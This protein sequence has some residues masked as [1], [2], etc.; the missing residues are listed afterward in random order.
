MVHLAGSVR[1][2]SSSPSRQTANRRRPDW[3]LPFRIWPVYG[4][5]TS[6]GRATFGPPG[7][8]KLEGLAVSRE[9]WVQIPTKAEH[10]VRDSSSTCAIYSKLSA[11]IN[12]VRSCMRRR[13]S[14]LV[15]RVLIYAE[16][17]KMRSQTL[18]IHQDSRRIRMEIG[19]SK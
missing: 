12:G 18:H 17:K 14:G 9:V 8:F 15:T 4:P 13:G 11:M 16:A 5:P 10:L 19:R 1:A 6:C 3:P 7:I 2:I